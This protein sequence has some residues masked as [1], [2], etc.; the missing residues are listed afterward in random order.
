MP[1]GS[2]EIL[3][4]CVLEANTDWGVQGHLE[5]H[6]MGIVV[7]WIDLCKLGSSLG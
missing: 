7:D 6:F 4:L 3:Q 2:L 1:P 5:E